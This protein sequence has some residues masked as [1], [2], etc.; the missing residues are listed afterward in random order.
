MISP[1]PT[2]LAVLVGLA[3]LVVLSE[4]ACAAPEEDYTWISKIRP[5]H[6]RLFFS[7]DTWPAV[8]ERAL[9]VNKDDYEKVKAHAGGTE[10]ENQYH[11]PESAGLQLPG[12]RPGSSVKV[13][14]WGRRLMS[15]ALV[16]RLE[17][18]PQG[19]QRIKDMLQA[20]L[21]YYHACYAVNWSPS[22]YSTS[23]VSW[24]AA[25]DWIWSDLSV[26]ERQQLGRG[27]IKHV[28]E[29]LHKPGIQRRNLGGHKSGY[30][31]GD[32]IAWFAGVVFFNEGIDDEK[33]LE[34]LK[35]GYAD[36]QKFLAYRSAIP[37]DDGGAAS[38]TIT[39]SFAAYPWAEW[40]FLYTWLSA[41]GED[42]AD[43]WPHI[44]MLSN[45]V[46]W[47][48]LPGNHEYGY[49]DVSHVA[50]NMPMS[51]LYAH[52]S[53][54]MHFW[55]KSH[56]DL[57]ALAAYVREK[58]GGGYSFNSWSVHPFLMTNLEK[59]PGP[60]GPGAL[61]PARHFENMGQVFMR[62]GSGEED[63]YA[64]F[65]C[66]G[67]LSGHKHYDATHFTIYKNGFL[68]LDTGTRWGNNEN[69]QNYYAQTVA[70]NCILIKM[71]G[72]PPT[73]YWN[74]KVYGQAGGQNK[75]IGSKVI[76]FDTNRQFSYVA[77]DATP[78]YSEKKCAQ[79]V[80]QFVFI[81][82][83]HFVVF[84]RV[85]ATKAEYAKRWLLHHANEPIVNGKTWYSDQDRG[86]IFS[87]TL[88]PEDAVLEKVGGP[89]KEFMADG[90][91]YPLTIGKFHG[92]EVPELMGRCRMEVKPGSPRAKDVFMHLIQVGDQSLE[93]MSDASVTT[94]DDTAQVAFDAGDKS[95]E[96][97]FA[98]TGDIAGHIRIS[99]GAKV[100]VDRELTQQVM[101][102]AGLASLDG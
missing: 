35:R 75:A 98:T 39:Y 85:T 55:G 78:V 14:D 40:N 91:N 77:G 70:H 47:N 99:A 92:K 25:C 82:P 53:H 17:P 33:A 93:A 18:D 41:T 84:D 100:L 23:R 76:A 7:A 11:L 48:W 72:E 15:A 67:I 37:G 94:T 95:V 36:Y 1:S 46:L 96:L 20:S 90:V 60:Q 31:G 26:S 42:I 97:S 12:P 86:R 71:P 59:A 44:A 68:A 56:A 43:N 89:G 49:G 19:L 21:D 74:G 87:R 69:L 57:A 62:S 27:M 28:N 79:M 61:P 16:Y 24:L 54:I 8:K 32:N 83:N 64:L 102:Q 4:A 34:F 81:P 13:G 88:L 2:L 58:A 50:N 51:C 73:P 30:Y 6:P 45:Y 101:P 80:R 52:M 63:T 9:T 22:W 66:G 5:D 65:A 10:P 29:V 3:V 38:P